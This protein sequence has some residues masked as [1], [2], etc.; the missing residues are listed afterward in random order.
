MRRAFPAASE[1]GLI[2][3]ISDVCHC[4]RNL[5]APRS[6]H[7]ATGIPVVKAL[8]P[9]CARVKLG[10]RPHFP[11]SHIAQMYRPSPSAFPVAVTNRR[12]GTEQ[13]KGTGILG[14]R[15]ET[16]MKARA[17]AINRWLAAGQ[18]INRPHEGS[19]KVATRLHALRRSVAESVGRTKGPMSVRLTPSSLRLI[20]SPASHL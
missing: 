2:L 11:L 7:Q 15:E 12:T 13:S 3:R 6:A 14:D 4:A 5:P 18:R 1:C 17:A 20:C 9:V 19:R 10:A 8:V 16:T